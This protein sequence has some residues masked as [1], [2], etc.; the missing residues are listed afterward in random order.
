[1]IWRSITIWGPDTIERSLKSKAIME[2]TS[3]RAGHSSAT[4]SGERILTIPILGSSIATGLR[5]L[6]EARRVTVLSRDGHADSWA[7]K[8]HQGLAAGVCLRWWHSQCL[9]CR[10]LRSNV[11]DTI[12]TIEIAI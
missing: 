9:A 12:E 10:I 3:R 8:R 4:S 5:V 7:C 6:E 1:V 11:G 2:L